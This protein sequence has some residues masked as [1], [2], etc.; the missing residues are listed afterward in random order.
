MRTDDSLACMQI[1]GAWALVNLSLRKY[2]GE[3][4]IRKDMSGERVLYI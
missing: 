2:G 4:A 1:V 3:A